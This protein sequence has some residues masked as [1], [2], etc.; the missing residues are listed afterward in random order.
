[1][2]LGLLPKITETDVQKAIKQYLELRGFRMYRRN[3]GGAYAM[4]LGREQFV[5]FSEPGAADLTGW[6][7][8]TGRTIEV[9]VKKPGARTNPKRQALQRAWLDQAKRDGCIAFRA[10]SVQEADEQLAAYGYEKR[11]L[12]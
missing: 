3:V 8:G 10:A 2:N 7:I 6:E 1:M 12:F 11:L 9:E 4:R 5:R